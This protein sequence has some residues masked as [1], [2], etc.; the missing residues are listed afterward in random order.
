MSIYQY[1]IASKIQ[2]AGIGLHNGLRVNLVIK[3][4]PENTGIVFRRIDLPGEPSIPASYKY[5]IDTNLATK[6]GIGEV[7]VSTVEHLMAALMGMGID[8]AIAE[9]DGPEIPSLDGSAGPFV[10]MLRKARP[11][12]QTAKRSFIKVIEPIL[13]RCEDKTLAIYPDNSLKISYDIDFEHL[14]IGRQ[15]CKLEF[16]EK[17]F[18]DQIASARTFGF[19]NEVKSL[20][21]NGLAL[22]GSLDNA[23]VIDNFSVLNQDGLRFEDEFVRHKVLDLLGDLALLGKP[24][25]GHVVAYKSGHALNHRLLQKMARQRE[26][27]T[28]CHRTSKEKPAS[29]EFVCSRIVTNAAL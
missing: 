14:L 23:V 27:W 15:S 24:L 3:P 18:C 1:T 28:V 20:Q 9:I 5:I 22:G 26:R 13:A 6:L 19:L 25:L 12:Q 7:S 2:C 17:A 16:T 11:V 10:S 4:A 29:S 8:N 21:K